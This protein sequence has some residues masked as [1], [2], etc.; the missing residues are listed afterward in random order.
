[1]LRK[2]SP[3]ILTLA[4]CVGLLPAPVEAFKGMNL[5]ADG[6]GDPHAAA[7]DAQEKFGLEALKDWRKVGRFVL[8]LLGAAAIGAAIAYPPFATRKTTIEDFDQPKII[9][10]YTVV[11]AL[12]GI[13]VAAEPALG[14]AIFGIGGLMRF[15]T[16]LGAAKETGRVILAT[17]LGIA[18]GINLWMVAIVT[19]VLSLVLIW[20]L[21]SRSGLRMV[22]RGLRSETISQSAEAY[23]KTLSALRCSFQPPRKNPKKGQI[24]FTFQHPRSLTPEDMEARLDAEVP[25]ELRGTIDWP[26]D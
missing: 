21:E 25:K 26:E 4:V 7:Q 14:I 3:L 20:F 11:G 16:E 18:C 2:R 24:S 22:I 17:I 9:I 1:M 10:T 23:A 6:G 5:L 13:V 8:E 15:R 19:T 12:V